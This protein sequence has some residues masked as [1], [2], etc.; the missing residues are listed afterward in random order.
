MKQEKFWT[1]N[2]TRNKAETSLT[3]L[4]QLKLEGTALINSFFTE[5]PKIN[6]LQQ[7]YNAKNFPAVKFYLIA[8]LYL[9]STLFC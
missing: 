7:Y 9:L 4:Q 2:Y 5:I 1:I 3:I 8:N 6:F